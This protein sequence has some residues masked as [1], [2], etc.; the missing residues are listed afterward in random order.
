VSPLI[1]IDF[2]LANLTFQA[3]QCLHSSKLDKPNDYR[4]ILQLI[5][6]SYS[7]NLNI[8]IFG[9]AAKTSK[10]APDQAD[11]FPLSKDLRNPFISNNVEAI[12]EAYSSCLKDI[13]LSTPIK[14]NPLLNMIKRL[15]Q[16]V[17]KLMTENSD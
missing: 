6:D 17:R 8:P 15:G 7:N 5:C 14:L 3:D 1:A 10:L 12:D 16:I 11:L 9:Y 4:D 2:S 13:E